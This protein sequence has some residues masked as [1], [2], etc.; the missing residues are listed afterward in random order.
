MLLAVLL[1]CSTPPAPPDVPSPEDAL[2]R[3]EAHVSAGRIDDA[4]ADAGVLLETLED[5][6]R[7]DLA[8]LRGQLQV[9]AGRPVMVPDGLDPAAAVR[10]VVD[11]LI[12]ETVA[13]L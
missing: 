2:A 8:M 6:R 4:I 3:I 5:D 1:A 12:E 10:G 11:Q 7:N 9:A 13:G